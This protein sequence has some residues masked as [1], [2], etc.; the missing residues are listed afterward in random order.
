[1]A[2]FVT[3][4]RFVLGKTPTV[5]AGYTMVNVDL[6]Q[7][8]GGEY[9]YLIYKTD[10]TGTEQPI[11]GLNVFADSSASGWPIQTGYTRINQDL[12]EGAG[13]KYIYACYTKKST[14]RP[15]TGVSVISGSSAQTFP[16]DSTWV[17][18]VQDCNEGAGGS[19][20]YICYQYDT[21]TPFV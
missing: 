2:A 15:L 10:T 19:Y 11:S 14:N 17:R 18:I 13:G 8:A 16:S 1:M 7:N 20:V 3:D 6:N 12:A 5:P 9:I 4:I 21:G